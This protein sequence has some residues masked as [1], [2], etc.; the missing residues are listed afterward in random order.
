[1]GADLAGDDASEEAAVGRAVA[2]LTHAGPLLGARWGAS[3]IPSDWR[4]LFTAG[5]PPTPTTWPTSRCGAREADRVHAAAL[6]RRRP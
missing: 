6:A 4:H 3:A 2:E 1:M 5:P